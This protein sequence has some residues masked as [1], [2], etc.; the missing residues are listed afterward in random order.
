MRRWVAKFGAQSAEELRRREPRPGRTWHLDEMAA[1]I[2]GRVHWLWRA[3][4]EHGRTLD[5]PLQAQR[6][7][8]AATRF[9]SRMLAAAD[10]LPPERITTERTFH[11]RATKFQQI[12]AQPTW[13]KARCIATR[14]SLVRPIAAA[15]VS[16][17]YRTTE[18]ETHVSVTAPSSHPGRREA[19][20]ADRT[21]RPSPRL[22]RCRQRPALP[23]T[24][25]A[26]PGPPASCRPFPRTS[27]W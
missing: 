11:N 10:G 20:P 26:R 24:D 17:H 3:V 25:S 6:E 21:S 1:R 15:S 19:R 4:D 13:R 5:V 2:G 16:R 8:A 22:P 12:S 18:R 23:S 27:P 9:F 7:T 14:C